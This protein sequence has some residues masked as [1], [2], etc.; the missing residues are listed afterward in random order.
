MDRFWLDLPPQQTVTETVAYCYSIRDSR[1]RPCSLLLLTF[2]FLLSFEH[3]LRADPHC[4]HPL[5]RRSLII[6]RRS[7]Y[8][9]ASLPP[10][11]CVYAL[12]RPRADMAGTVVPNLIFDLDFGV[13]DFG[14]VDI[15]KVPNK[16]VGN[17]A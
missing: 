16:E 9:L 14:H 17:Y 10:Q 1:L 15:N 8:S 5:L 4:H 2:V 7:I 3:T 12:T 6:A 13:P 11:F